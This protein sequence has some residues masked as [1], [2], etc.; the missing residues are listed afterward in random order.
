MSVQPAVT[1][2][3]TN[4]LTQIATHL[5]SPDRRLDALKLLAHSLQRTQETGQPNPL[6]HEQHRAQCERV[7]LGFQSCLQVNEDDEQTLMHTNQI[8][9]D[10]MPDILKYPQELQTHF[11]NLISFLI[12]NLGNPKVILSL[13]HTITMV[14]CIGYRS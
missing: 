11:S 4:D 9:Y 12:L 14:L 10:M 6:C 5:L 3:T 7:F 8:L 1:Q 13:S 2:L